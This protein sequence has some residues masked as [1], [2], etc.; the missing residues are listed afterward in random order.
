MKDIIGPIMAGLAVVYALTV[1]LSA[2]R[3]PSGLGLV[4]GQ[5]RLSEFGSLIQTVMLQRHQQEPGHKQV[6][7]SQQTMKVQQAL[8]DHGFYAGPVDGVMRQGT[9]EAI[10]SFQ[11]SRDLEVTGRV[12]D[13]TARELHIR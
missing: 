2:D 8:K 13:D 6:P 3:T 12:N 1:L 9:Q 7:N 11:R 4:K 10:E 5:E